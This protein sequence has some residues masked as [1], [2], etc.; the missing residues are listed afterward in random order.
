MRRLVSP[1]ISNGSRS[2]GVGSGEWGVGGS[3]EWGGVGSGE[4]GGALFT[5]W[6]IIRIAVY[7]F[8]KLKWLCPRSYKPRIFSNQ[9]LQLSP[10]YQHRTGWPRGHVQESSPVW[11]RATEMEYM[12]QRSLPRPPCK[13]HKCRSLKNPPWDLPETTSLIQ[14]NVSKIIRK[15]HNPP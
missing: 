13:T 15:V 5:G 8:R 12:L 4:W 11:C 7:L 14:S 10:Q 3:G 9:G 1:S 6:L 2:Q